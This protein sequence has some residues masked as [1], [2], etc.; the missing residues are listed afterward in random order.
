MLNLSIEVVPQRHSLFLPLVT[1]FETST[2]EF[3]G[4]TRQRHSLFLPLVRR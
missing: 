2:Q 4:Q 1:R 3:T